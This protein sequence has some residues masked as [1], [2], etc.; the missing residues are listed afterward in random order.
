[1]DVRDVFA[2][3]GSIN[4]ALLAL[5]QQREHTHDMKGRVLLF[6][7]TGIIG[8]PHEMNDVG[9]YV[10]IVDGSACTD[11][12]G[13]EVYPRGGYGI[14]VSDLEMQTA[15]EMILLYRCVECAHAV[16]RYDSPGGIFYSHLR[17]PADEHEA[18]IS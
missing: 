1:M 6:P 15:I 5:P 13:R 16:E 7:R 11:E 8:V 4:A 18:R 10:T 3:E 17:H 14:H 12:N 9:Y 2:P